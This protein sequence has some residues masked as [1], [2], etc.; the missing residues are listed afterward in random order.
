M[1]KEI[2]SIECRIWSEPD[3]KHCVHE[4][5]MMEAEDVFDR[6]HDHLADEDMLPDEYFNFN[7]NFF[8]G[9]HEYYQTARELPKNF[10]HFSAE[11]D[12]GGSEGIYLD[13]YVNIPGK[14]IPFATGKTLSEDGNAFINM[15]RIAA[16]CLMFLNGSGSII[17]NTQNTDVTKY[18]LQSSPNTPYVLLEKTEKDAVLKRYADIKIDPTPYVIA[19]GI[20]IKGNII[21]WDH[22]TYLKDLSEVS[23][24]LLKGHTFPLL[25]D[26]INI[27]GY[28]GTWYIIDTKKYDNKTLYLLESEIYGDEAACLIVNERRDVIMDYVWN[29]FADLD[30][31]I[32]T[33]EEDFEI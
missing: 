10:S 12:W 17:K 3:E 33:D 15:S 21:E 23:E 18:Y 2:E 27:D 31:K 4:I 13:I 1:E 11:T 19:H 25:E 9:S 14:R 32:E 6:L 28:E 24:Y 29:G 16:E 30:Y 7:D 5:G 8:A 26:N 22:G 20:N